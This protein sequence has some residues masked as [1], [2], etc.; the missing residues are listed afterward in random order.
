MVEELPGCSDLILDIKL[1]KLKKASDARN[2]LMVISSNSESLRLFDM[3]EKK[4]LLLPGHSDMVLCLDTRE[5]YILSG[6]K[7]TTVKMWKVENEATSVT[8]L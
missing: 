7:D 5:E 3:Q 1:L 8:F 4:N 6:G 2:D